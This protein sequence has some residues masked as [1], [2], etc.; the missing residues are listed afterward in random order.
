MEAE[1]MHEAPSYFPYCQEQLSQTAF[2]V[3]H[4]LETLS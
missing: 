3:F 2:F 4:L 1:D